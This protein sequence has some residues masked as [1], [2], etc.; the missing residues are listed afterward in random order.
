MKIELLHV[1]DCAHVDEARR[2]L[3]SC[4]VEVGIDVTIDQREVEYPSPTILI[5]GED[6]MGA[7]GA[8]G[9]SCRLD[10]PTRERILTALSQAAGPS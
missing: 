4:L 2:T 5:D 9:A 10:V 3:E 6:V 1:A 7:P 8:A